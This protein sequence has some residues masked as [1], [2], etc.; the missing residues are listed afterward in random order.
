MHL[1]APVFAALVAGDL[2]AASAAG[3][4][5]LPASFAV[6]D[7]VPVWAMRLEQVRADPAGAAWVTGVIWDDDRELRYERDPPVG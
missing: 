7:W 1:D 3:P 5:P 2:P 6:P 4:V